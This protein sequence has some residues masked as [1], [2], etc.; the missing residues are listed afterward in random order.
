M[1][2]IDIVFDGSA[3]HRAEAGKFVAIDDA[4][5]L[6]AC[7]ELVQEIAQRLGRDENV[8]RFDSCAHLVHRLIGFLLA[9]RF[10]RHAEFRL[11]R[12]VRPTIC[13]YERA[14]L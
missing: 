4:V 3:E 5:L 8:Q 13:G 14:V 10:R 11:Q 1:L 6:T 2:E 9:V 12:S 7:V